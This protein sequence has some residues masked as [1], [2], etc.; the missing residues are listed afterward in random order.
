MALAD[1]VAER[2]NVAS[3]L[4]REWFNPALLGA[5]LRRGRRP[6]AGL[7]RAAHAGSGRRVRE[8]GVMLVDRHDVVGTDGW[9]RTWGEYW[10]PPRSRP[11]S[12]RVLF[13]PQPDRLGEFVDA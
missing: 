4:Y 9:W 8:D 12:I 10:T 2:G 1:A 13:T 3:V 7:Y 5:D 11:G 6:L